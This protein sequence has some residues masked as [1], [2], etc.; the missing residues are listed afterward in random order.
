MR[1]LTLTLLLVGV[2]IVVAVR[3][4]DL[5]TKLLVV[6]R[7]APGIG[8]VLDVAVRSVSR[9]LE[10]AFRG[11]MALPEAVRPVQ[12]NTSA[13]G[14]TSYRE[15]GGAVVVRRGTDQLGLRGVIRSARLVVEPRRER[16]GAVVPEGILKNAS[17]VPL[18]AGP[19]RE[20]PDGAKSLQTVIEQLGDPSLRR[21]RFFLVADSAGRSAV[22]LVR[23]W[24]HSPAPA[25][26]LEL[27]LDF[28]D[29]DAVSLNPGGEAGAAPS[30]S[31]VVTGGPLD[32]LVWFVAQGPE[33]RAP[34]YDAARDP[35]SMRFPHP[36]LAVAAFEGDGR[37][38]ITRVG[39]EVE[40]LQVAWGL[41]GAGDA[42]AWRGDVA[43]S[44][45][46]GAKELV[47]PAGRPLLR[48]L[49][50]AMTAKAEH[51]YA[52]GDG[53]QPPV[54]FVPPLNAPAPDSLRGVG[55]VGW[56][57]DESRRIPFERMTREVVIAPRGVESAAP[58]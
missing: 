17:S 14:V 2:V 36:Y 54:D 31:E 20:D 16:D 22:A 38:G 32:D 42:L 45:A 47:D 43:G 51:R 11:G 18:R 35:P 30:L 49:K 4:I 56:S 41:A 57:P 9:D 10:G 12:D 37:W 6:E 33:G 24:S 3:L 28:T 13:E 27:L 52:R 8:G 7:D 26:A 48:A 25:L 58:R 44:P 5:R 23:S 15:A 19:P 50:I 34:D 53:P 29:P 39:E 1:E 55:P 46:P 21:K 40:E